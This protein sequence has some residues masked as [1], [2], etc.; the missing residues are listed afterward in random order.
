M[1]D[2]GSND[3]TLERVE[4]FT[5]DYPNISIQSFTI[6]SLGRA[7]QMNVGLRHSSGKYLVFC[8]ADTLLPSEW[9]HKLISI[10]SH[11]NIKLAY[12]NL[13]FNFV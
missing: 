5:N 13:Q 7:F 11:K 1:V 12:F 10:L 4:E 8:H 2:G 3:N 6:S 9:D